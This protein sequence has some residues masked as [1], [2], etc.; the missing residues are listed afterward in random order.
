MK[1]L[2]CTLLFLITSISFGQKEIKMPE[3]D[4]DNKVYILK[5]SPDS[6]NDKVISSYMQGETEKDSLR[7]WAEGTIL[8]QKV[9]VTV[10]SSEDADIKVD[11]VK[12]N[13]KDSKIN[14]LTKNGLFQES[15]E[16]AGK[17]GIVVSSSIPNIPF[18]LA[19]WTTG[20]NIPFMGNLFYPA[21]EA[22][23]ARSGQAVNNSNSIFEP[24]NGSGTGSTNTILYVVI[25]FFSIITILLVLLL[26]K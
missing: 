23:A 3:L 24:Q 10:I 14:G 7:F 21:N 18:Q 1:N 16:T 22:A 25:G 11:I 15:F 2:I 13:W 26:V 20:E 4:T 17:F 6:Q 8:L 19:V 9:M 12:A 5:F